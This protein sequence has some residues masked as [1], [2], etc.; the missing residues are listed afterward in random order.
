MQLRRQLARRQ[1]AEVALRAESAFRKAMEDLMLTGMRA[2][3]DG[4][5]H[6]RQPG[7]LP[8]DGFS[9]DELLGPAG[10][11]CPTGTRSGSERPEAPTR[12]ILAGGSSPTELRSCGARTA[13]Y[14]TRWC[15]RRR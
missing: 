15:S 13:R 7:L 2:R 9:A 14:S 12:Q 10:R 5:H 3:P 1:Q 11:R 4:R 6:L 8:H